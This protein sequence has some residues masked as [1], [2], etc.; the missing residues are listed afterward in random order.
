[1]KANR[2]RA[3]ILVLAIGG[4]LFGSCVACLGFAY[5]QGTRMQEELQAARAACEPPNVFRPKAGKDDD[6]PSAD[7]W[8]CVSPDVIAVEEENRR[9][10]EEAMRARQAA[11]E[12]AQAQ[13]VRDAQDESADPGSEAS[14]TPEPAAEAD[15]PMR[16]NRDTVGCDTEDRYDRALAIARSGGNVFRVQGCT[17]MREGTEVSL[18]RSNGFPPTLLLVA[19]LNTGA[20]YWVAFEHVDRP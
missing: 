2:R 20:T 14:P 10:Q 12:A 19:D 16:I 15:P 4:V 3:L 9:E 7:D 18:V 1:M 8:E 13:R 6:A 17:T 5:F 11:A